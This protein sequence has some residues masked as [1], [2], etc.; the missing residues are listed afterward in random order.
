MRYRY[1]TQVEMTETVLKMCIIILVQNLASEFSGRTKNTEDLGFLFQTTVQWKFFYFYF[2]LKPLQT[3]GLNKTQV[4]S[5]C[6]LTTFYI[7]THVD[8]SYEVHVLPK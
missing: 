7:V 8:R 3:K 4:T 6:L 2:Y 1:I 5:K